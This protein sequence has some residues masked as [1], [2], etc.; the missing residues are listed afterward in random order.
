LRGETERNKR[1]VKF[2]GRLWQE[3]EL[4]FGIDEYTNKGGNNELA[5]VQ[6][7]E[8]RKKERLPTDFGKIDGG[9]KES[10]NTEWSQKFSFNKYND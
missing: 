1:G 5:L 8:N 4:I 3:E 9:F 7:N 6:C 2:C 10:I